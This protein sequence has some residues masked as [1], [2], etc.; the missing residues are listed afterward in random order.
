MVAGYNEQGINWI[1]FSVWENLQKSCRTLICSNFL[2]QGTVTCEF[3][4][5][6]YISII[7]NSHILRILLNLYRYIICMSTT[8]SCYYCFNKHKWLVINNLFSERIM[9]VKKEELLI[10]NFQ[11]WSKEL[12][13]LHTI[14]RGRAHKPGNLKQ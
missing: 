10:I 7:F 3:H 4:I 9:I 6:L 12:R 13:K 11:V 2:R 5:V 14:D 8:F 1:P